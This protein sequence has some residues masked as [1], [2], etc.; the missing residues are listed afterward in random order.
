MHII[1]HAQAHGKL[2]RLKSVI[3]ARK[4][5]LIKN[6]ALFIAATTYAHPRFAL[7]VLK[8][9]IA[10]GQLDFTAAKIGVPMLFAPQVPHSEKVAAMF[11]SMKLQYRKIINAKLRLS[12][13]Q[14]RT[15]LII[16]AYIL[17]RKGIMWYIRNRNARLLQVKSQPKTHLK[18]LMKV[19]PIVLKIWILDQMM[20]H[21]KRKKNQPNQTLQF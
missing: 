16:A 20:I 5:L 19:K 3:P 13:L 7:S 17:N 15:L 11:W 21:Q 9:P 10:L 14:Y 2:A 6:L 18:N 4:T 1:L 8:T 12:V